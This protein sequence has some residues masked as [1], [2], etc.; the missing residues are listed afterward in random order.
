MVLRDFFGLLLSRGGAAQIVLRVAERAKA[1][2]RGIEI[3]VRRSRVV[4]PDETG[5]KV[6]RWLQWLWVFVVRTATLF[7]IRDSRGYDVPEEVLGAE[8]SGDMVHD[9]WMPYDSFE[10]ADHQSAWDTSSDDVVRSWNARLEEPYAFLAQS[11]TSSETPSVCATAGTREKSRSMVW[12]SRSVGWR[13]DWT[14]CW[15]GAFP[16]R[17]TPGSRD[18]WSVI[19]TSSSCS[20]RSPGSRPPVGRLIKPFVPPSPTEKS[21]AEIVI[22]E[23]PKLRRS[24]PASPLLAH[25]VASAS[26]TTSAVSSAPRRVAGTP[27]PAACLTFLVRRRLFDHPGMRGGMKNASRTTC[28]SISAYFACGLRMA[29]SPGGRRPPWDLVSDYGSP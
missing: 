16:T 12:R 10:Q 2:Y 27:S 21:L 23:A 19:T 4:Y 8:W 3:V 5:W 11:E 17:S 1:A 26:S 29:S 9:G 6:G 7:K 22:P 15:D 24:S 14:D 25:S 28:A 20:L 18:I 13:L